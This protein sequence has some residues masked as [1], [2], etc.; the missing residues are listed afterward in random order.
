MYACMYVCMVVWM[1]V[2]MYECMYVLYVCK[3]VCMLCM[4]IMIIMVTILMINT[5]IKTLFSAYHNVKTH[6]MSHQ[7]W[8]VYVIDSYVYCYQQLRLIEDL[9][10]QNHCLKK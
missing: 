3:Y 5:F 1:N 8:V 6:P 10:K 4:N 2:Y 9:N 7:I